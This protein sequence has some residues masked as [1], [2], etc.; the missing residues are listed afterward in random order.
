MKKSNRLVW[1]AFF[2]I[3]GACIVAMIMLK[4]GMTP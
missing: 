1:G 3:L 2:L 4:A